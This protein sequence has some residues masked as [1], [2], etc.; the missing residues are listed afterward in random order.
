MKENMV[1]W[2]VT[3]VAFFSATASSFAC[4]AWKRAEEIGE[5]FTWAGF[6]SLITAMCILS[7]FYIFMSDTLSLAA[8][9]GIICGC[10]ILGALI[11]WWAEN[12]LTKV[13]DDTAKQMDSD[14]KEGN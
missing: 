2:C 5:K 6:M 9:I 11:G 4:F 7:N 13:L 8:S 1:F 12:L 3:F 14:E 10:V